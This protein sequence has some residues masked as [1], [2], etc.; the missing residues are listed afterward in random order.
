ME[1]KCWLTVRGLMKSRSATSRRSA[2][3]PPTAAPRPRAGSDQPGS[4][5]DLG[6][7]SD[8]RL[9]ASSSA[10]ARRGAAPRAAANR[11][12]LSQCPASPRRPSTRRSSAKA[13]SAVARTKGAAQSRRPIR[14]RPPDDA[15]RSANWPAS[16]ARRPSS[17]SAVMQHRGAGPGSGASVSPSA[18]ARASGHTRRRMVAR[19]IHQPVSPTETDPPQEIHRSCASSHARARGSSAR[20]TGLRQGARGAAPR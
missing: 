4:Q 8:A 11:H 7:D 13:T 1:R 5:R 16:F 10:A 17:R 18:Q 15:P 9:D 3:R 2:L 14:A 12:R 19:P 20:G 6:R